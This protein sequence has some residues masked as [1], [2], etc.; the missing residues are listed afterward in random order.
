[1][2]TE[3]SSSVITAK[4]KNFFDAALSGRLTEVIELSNQ[5]SN[6]VE[7][8]SKALIRSCT[9]GHLNVVKWLGGCTAADVN[10]YNNE[11]WGWN[12]PLTAACKNNHLN[13]VKY[14][15]ETCQVDVNL[16]DNRGN[17][18]LA[19]ACLNVNMSMLMYFLCE[20]SDLDVNVAYS[21]GNTALHLAVW[22]S[23]DDYTQLHEACERGNV[24]EVLRLVYV[25]GHKIN[26][27]DNK[28]FTPLHIACLNGHNDIVETLMLAGADETITN[29]IGKTPAQ[30]AE[31]VG[32]SE[33]LKLL[34]RDSLL[35]VMLGRK[36]KSKLS[37]V[38]LVMLTMRLM[39]QRQIARN[40]S[41]T[42]T[43]VH[44]ML[45]IKRIINFHRKKLQK[46]NRKIK[47]MI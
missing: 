39:K 16:S 47:C 10:Y 2:I 8:C 29:D 14:L 34:D 30:W 37:L 12:T 9:R 7:A 35:K 32:H 3:I 26:V 25:E 45:T 22:C 19:W 46:P 6:D 43:A 5:L 11:G 33:L 28:G 18:S 40:W 1:M 13:L 20:V 24:T 23:E 27:Q 15:V 36:K 38:V 41:H 4:R 42:L 17:T 21:D 44:I 31:T